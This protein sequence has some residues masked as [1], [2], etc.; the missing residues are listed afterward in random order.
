MANLTI[1]ESDVSLVDVIEKVTGPAGE[2]F[3]AGSLVHYGTDGRTLKGAGTATTTGIAINGADIANKTVTIVKRGI[4]DLG[5]ALAGL[6]FGDLVYASATAG[7][8]ATTG[9]VVVG[10]VVPALA[11]SS[12]TADKL[13]RVR[14]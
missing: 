13:L 2:V 5:A 8:L 7:L 9:T 14:L 3:T 1:T 6:A 12:A 10:D 11:N 4:V